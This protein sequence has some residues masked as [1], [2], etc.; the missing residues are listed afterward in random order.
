MPPVSRL[1]HFCP[2]RRLNR[3]GEEAPM[4]NP[5]LQVLANTVNKLLHRDAYGP[6]RKILSKRHPA[7][8]A[9]FF[10]DFT[11]VDRKRLFENCG[12]DQVKAAVL[13]EIDLPVAVELISNQDPA[14]A[15][16]ILNNMDSDDLADLLEELDEDLKEKLLKLFKDEDQEAVEELMAY[17]ASTAGG[18]MNP[19]FLALPQTATAGEAVDFLQNSS[20]DY[21]ITFYIYVINSAEKLSGVVSLRQLVTCKPSTTLRELM[22]PEVISVP[23]SMDQEEVAEI[24]QRY[25]FLAVPVVDDTN[26]MVGVVTVDD[27]IEVI[28]EEAT[29]DIFKMSGAGQDIEYFQDSFSE[30]FRPRFTSIFFPLLTGVTSSLILAFRRP[31]FT[32]ASGRNI[33]FLLMIPI[34][35]VLSSAIANQSGSL[36]VRGIALGRVKWAHFIEVF[37]RETAMSL[38]L[39]LLFGLFAFGFAMIPIFTRNGSASLQVVFPMF[40]GLT[41]FF[42]MLFAGVVG[43]CLPLVFK[44]MN[45]DPASAAGSILSG[46]VEVFTILL[47]V[48]LISWA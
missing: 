22:T 3:P 1:F 35:L 14:D 19:S 40:V 11:P 9:Y 46:L 44:R 36:M 30:R 13:G 29:E 38:M 15:V 23:V 34:L 6:L 48:F 45:L 32:D 20:E 18:I 31:F 17:D 5:K 10:R 39:G 28:R 43:A 16:H 12:D 24:V 33:F 26:R 41:V 7:E 47:Y 2:R 21:A 25:G 27:V 8:L 37:R 4:Q 42:S